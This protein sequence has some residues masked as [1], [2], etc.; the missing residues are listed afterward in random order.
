MRVSGLLLEKWKIFM[1]SFW[2]SLLEM[3]PFTEIGSAQSHEAR[4]IIPVTEN[5]LGLNLR[6]SLAS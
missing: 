4:T 2:I 1:T 3:I 5:L 6:E